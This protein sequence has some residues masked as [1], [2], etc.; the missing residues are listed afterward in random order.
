[1]FVNVPFERGKAFFSNKWK[2][3]QDF[4]S[5]SI[6]N[7]SM[8]TKTDHIYKIMRKGELL[9]EVLQLTGHIR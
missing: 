5:G 3:N 7:I 1:M 4:S 9:C 2:H 8:L 6:Q